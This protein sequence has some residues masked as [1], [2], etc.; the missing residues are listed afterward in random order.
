MR[1]TGNRP[2]ARHTTLQEAQEEA[3]RIAAQARRPCEVWV[4][5]CKTVKTVRAA[6]AATGDGSKP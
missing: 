1:S 3:Q 4:I 5:E 2:K 6:L